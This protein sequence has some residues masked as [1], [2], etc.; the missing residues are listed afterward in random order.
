[1][2]ASTSIVVATA[3][4]IAVVATL[5]V[6]R[7]NA[8]GWV[9]LRAVVKNYSEPYSATDTTLDDA[10][11]STAPSPSSAFSTLAASPPAPRGR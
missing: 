8:V 6:S 4:K 10:P 2:V 5:P 7:D 9:Q 1:V 11:R 3:K